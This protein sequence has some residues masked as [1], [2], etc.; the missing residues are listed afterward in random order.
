M[1]TVHGILQ[2]KEAVGGQI[3]CS[4]VD[5]LG[6]YA[7]QC[8]DKVLFHCVDGPLVGYW[9]NAV[10]STLPTKPSWFA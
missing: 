8:T 1:S 2:R 9:E 10:S 3:G 4:Y 5:V 7:S 6:H